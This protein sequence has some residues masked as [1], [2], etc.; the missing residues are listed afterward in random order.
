MRINVVRGLV[1]AAVL[2]GVVGACT[3]P[4]ADTGQC[5]PGV[6]DISKIGATLPANC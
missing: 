4:M 5:E 3:K 2:A 6:S 1:A